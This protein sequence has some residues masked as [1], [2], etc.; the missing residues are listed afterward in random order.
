MKAGISIG[1]EPQTS[2]SELGLSFATKDANTS[3]RQPAVTP[4]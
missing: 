3:F 2:G 4:Y 1:R